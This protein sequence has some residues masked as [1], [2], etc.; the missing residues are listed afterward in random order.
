[1]AGDPW[2][3][4]VLAALSGICCGGYVGRQLARMFPWRERSAG[5]AG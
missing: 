3:V 4:Y 2:W 5:D 1:M